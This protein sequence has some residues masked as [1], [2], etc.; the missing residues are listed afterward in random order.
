MT[1][2][3]W[4]LAAAVFLPYVWTGVGV[5]CK[6]QQ[7]GSINFNE[8]RSQ[9]AKLGGVGA[10]AH[11]AQLNAWEALLVFASAVFVAHL[12][13][14]NPSLSAIASM[15]FV[16]ARVFHGVVYLKN[17]ASLRSLCFILGF[18]CCLWLFGLAAMA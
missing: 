18:G 1:T 17:I 5:Y 15:I 16:G 7:F 10:R 3:F 13:G 11:A 9:S 2:P 6:K 4:C 8:P 14:A 12:A